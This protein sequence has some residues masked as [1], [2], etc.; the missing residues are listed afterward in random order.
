MDRMLGVQVVYIPTHISIELSVIS[1]ET[2]DE[3][4]RQYPGQVQAGF[5]TSTSAVYPGCVFC[6]YWLPGRAGE[7]L[8]TM[9]NS[10]L[11]PLKLLVFHRTATNDTMKSALCGLGYSLIGAHWESPY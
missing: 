4:L 3:L 7:S 9:A 2:V 11:T 1:P 10:E 6:K 8:R 5:I